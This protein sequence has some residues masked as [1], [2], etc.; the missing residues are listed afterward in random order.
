MVDALAAAAINH[1]L[2][3][4]GWAR[5]RFRPFAGASVRFVMT[6]FTATFLISDEGTLQPAGSDAEPAATIKLTPSLAA[7]LVLLKDESARSEVEVEGD[8]ALAAAL[9]RVLGTLT[10]DVEEDLSRVV[11]DVAAHRI[12]RAGRAFLDWQ[13]AVAANLARS[14]GEYLSEEQP[15]IASRE[16]LDAFAQAV[17]ELRDDAERLG[18]RIQRL[19]SAPPADRRG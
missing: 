11:G 7:R 17:D 14:V 1:L 2:R 19:A 16:A 4:A 6:P 13:A 15:A 10:W 12:A 5:E 9:T 8:A 18:K 3:G